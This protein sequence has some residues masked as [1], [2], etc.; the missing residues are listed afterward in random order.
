LCANELELRHV[1]ILYSKYPAP[2]PRKSHAEVQLR[3][4]RVKN[5]TPRGHKGH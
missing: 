5:R 4:S 1:P 3:N 2:L